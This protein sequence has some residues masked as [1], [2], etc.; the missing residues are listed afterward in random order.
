MD[1]DCEQISTRIRL[2]ENIVN[3]VLAFGLCS[4]HQR[5]TKAYFFDFLRRNTMPGDV[6]NP[7]LGPDE[8]MDP[9]DAILSPTSP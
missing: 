6:V 5:A 7:I 8:F 1:D 2:S 3:R 9:H 4:L